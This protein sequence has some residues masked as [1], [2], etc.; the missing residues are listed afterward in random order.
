LARFTLLTGDDGYYTQAVPGCQAKKTK[1]SKKVAHSAL[2]LKFKKP[3]YMEKA[4]VSTAF[5]RAFF[6]RFAVFVLAFAPLIGI[7]PATDVWQHALRAAN[8]DGG[9]ASP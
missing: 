7:Q 1:F 6:P 8:G 3:I 4:H 2:R 5:D 9:A